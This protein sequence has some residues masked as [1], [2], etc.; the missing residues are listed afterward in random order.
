MFRVAVVLITAC[1]ALSACA[2]Q[3]EL[4]T[5]P[6]APGFL[7]GLLH[8]AIAPFSL[9]ASLF[10]NVRAYAFPNSGISYDLGFLLG[11]LVWAGSTNYIYIKHSASSPNP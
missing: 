4:A 8:G 10:T 2:T 5:D 1:A 9:L 7:N 6:N 11:V 3:P